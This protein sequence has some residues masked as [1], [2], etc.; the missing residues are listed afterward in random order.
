MPEFLIPKVSFKEEGLYQVLQEVAGWLWHEG[1]SHWSKQDQEVLPGCPSPR[2]HP[3]D[4]D[5]WRFVDQRG[6]S[7]FGSCKSV[8]FPLVYFIAVIQDCTDNDEKV[9]GTPARVHW[10]PCVD[11]IHHAAFLLNVRSFHPQ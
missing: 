8:F 11:W 2:P 6:F 5:C 9:D 1:H 10:K 3:G 4:Y 7:Y